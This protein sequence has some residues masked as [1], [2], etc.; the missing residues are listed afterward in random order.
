[1]YINRVSSKQAKDLPHEKVQWKG[2]ASNILPHD[3]S[4]R[5]SNFEG[6]GVFTEFSRII[7]DIA[8]STH[9]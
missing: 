6:G 1:M 9:A 2:T 8:L 5:G 4:N 7:S 3:F